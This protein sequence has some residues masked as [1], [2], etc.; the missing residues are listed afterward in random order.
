MRQEKAHENQQVRAHIRESLVRW[1]KGSYGQRFVWCHR[2]DRALHDGRCAV[3]GYSLN[4][5]TRT[6]HSNTK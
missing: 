2:H 6:P 1:F 5:T 3:R 4:I